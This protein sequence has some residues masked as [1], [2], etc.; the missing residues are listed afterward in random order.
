MTAM[1]HA[2]TPRLILRSPER[3]DLPRIV[4]LLGAWDVVRWLA[5]V[6]YPYTL[7]SAEEFYARMLEALQKGAP[8]Y[9]LLQRKSD[10]AQVGAIGLHPSREPRPQPGELVIGYWL[11]KPFWGQGLMSEAVK[12]VIDIAFARDGVA[13]LTSTTDPAN[14]ASQSVLRKAGLRFLGITPRCD[15][16]ALR[17]S[18]EVTRWQL[19]REEYEAGKET[20]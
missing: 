17:G 8:E 16:G 1:I 7:E 11:G 20:T 13:V 2:E 19:T 18:L 10:G 15:A 3:G 12:S 14:A 6:P 9:F 4:E 5:A